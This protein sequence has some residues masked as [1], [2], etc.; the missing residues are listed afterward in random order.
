MDET[1]STVTLKLPNG[2]RSYPVFHTSLLLPFTDNDD[3]LFPSRK[4][5]PHVVQMP[6]G[7]TEYV[8]DQILDERKI[9]RGL[10]YLVRWRGE[11]LE[12]DR[13]LP[14]RELEKCKALNVWLEQRHCRERAPP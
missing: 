14:R 2:D 7:S 12:E 1:H 10:Q 13:W 3:S 4:S 11:G 6:D 9:G 5:T 8:I